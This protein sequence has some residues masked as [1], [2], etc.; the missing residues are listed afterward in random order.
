[1]NISRFAQN[2][3]KNIPVTIFLA[4]MAAAARKKNTVL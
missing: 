3:G 4:R 1:M 2:S